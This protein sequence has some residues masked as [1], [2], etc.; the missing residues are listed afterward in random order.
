MTG[1]AVADRY[2]RMVLWM[3][4]ALP[5]AALAILSTLFFVAE[6]LDPEAA[7][8][9]ADVDVE[10]ILTEQGV[11]GPVYGGVTE[12]GMAVSLAAEVIRPNEDKTRLAAEKMIAALDLPGGAHIDIESLIG[13]V[14]STTREATLEGGA[15]LDVFVRVLHP[16]FDLDL[17]R[18]LLFQR[19]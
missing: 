19:F 4:V 12:D 9:Y 3:K 15:R 1:M 2:S 11:T 7:I 16:A 14:D 8:P 6:T 5:L 10:R 13:T 17:V 18:F